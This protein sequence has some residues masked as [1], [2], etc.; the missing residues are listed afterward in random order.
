M[1]LHIADIGC[2]GGIL[3]L[4]LARLGATVIAM[5]ASEEVVEAASSLVK[6]LAK[7]IDGPGSVTFLCTTAEKFVDNNSESRL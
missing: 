6:R 4:C 2:G 5:D 7:S 1:G 3:S